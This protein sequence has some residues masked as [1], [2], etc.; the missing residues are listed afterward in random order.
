MLMFLV[1]KN[2]LTS[3]EKNGFLLAPRHCGCDI[4]NLHGMRTDPPSPTAFQRERPR[5]HGGVLLV[6]FLGEK[7][8]KKKTFRS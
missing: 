5:H 8:E 6:E 4:W 1:N 2:D 7:K 3:P